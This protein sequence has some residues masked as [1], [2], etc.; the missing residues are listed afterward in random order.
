[1]NKDSF[2][3]EMTEK[4]GSKYTLVGIYVDTHTETL[5]IDNTRI[6]NNLYTTPYNL[7]HE[8]FSE[9]D[10][11]FGTSEHNKKRRYIRKNKKSNNKN[12]EAF[13][14]KLNEKFPNTYEIIGEY[15]STN[16]KVRVKHIC[17][18]C[19]Y[20]EWDVTPSNLLIGKGSCPRC[21]NKERGHDG[22]VRKMRLAFGDEYLVRSIYTGAFNEVKL[23]HNTEYCHCEFI[24][25]ANKFF[26]EKVL[27]PEC[28]PFSKGEDIIRKLLEKLSIKFKPQFIFKDCKYKSYLRF[29]FGILDEYNNVLFLIEYQGLQHYKPCT[30]NGVS[31]EK[32]EETFKETQIKDKIK[33]DYCSKNKIPL[34]EITYKE[35]NNIEEILTKKLIEFNLLN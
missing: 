16:T 4:Y 12:K 28:S 17:K 10:Y 18:D 35:I 20:Y 22:F 32:A 24:T 7:L 29:D 3:R 31:K 27:C 21:E 5:F 23:Q 34:L 26:H 19:D 9:E 11:S 8:C 15:I 2:I 1:M 33:K 6:K 13:L 14:V 25:T 30:F